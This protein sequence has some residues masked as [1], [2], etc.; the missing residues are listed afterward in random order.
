M[1]FFD[2]AGNSLDTF[3]VLPQSAATTAPHGGLSFFGALGNAGERI[4]RVRITT[5]NTALGPNDQNGDNPDVVVMDDFMY[6]EPEI[7][8]EPAT[9]ALAAIGL[10]ALSLTARRRKLA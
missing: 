7:I 4:A 8:P 2:L 6:D 10:A 3:N 5:G 1:Q 9:A